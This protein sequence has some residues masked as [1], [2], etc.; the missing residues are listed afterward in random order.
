MRSCVE[1]I[2]FW[3]F[4][5]GAENQ[6]GI[7]RLVLLRPYASG[8]HKVRVAFW[9]G[10]YEI[11]H[12]KFAGSGIFFSVLRF[13]F[14]RFFFRFASQGAVFWQV[15][16]LIDEGN[17]NPSERKECEFPTFVGRAVLKAA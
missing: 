14:I 6:R 17:R 7:A 13:R 9:G 4:S 10:S 1:V 12:W 16:I 5:C 8:N 3:N 2:D 15:G 11:G